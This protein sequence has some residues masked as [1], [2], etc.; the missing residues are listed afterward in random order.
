MS[1]EPVKNTVPAGRVEIYDT[2]L[3]D[4]AQGEGV[5]F[6]LQDKLA[7][8][9]KLDE[10]R[11]DYIEGGY[12]L[13]NAKD[14][15]FFK[16]IRKIELKHSK[17]AA[18]GMTRRRG[19]KAEED[20]CLL[21]LQKSLAPVVT[22]VGKGWD[23]QVK[24]V[25]GVSLE[26]NMKMVADSCSFL[27]KKKRD[28]FF[29]AEHFFD[30]YK[31][32]PVYSLKVLQAAADAG[33][34]RF[35]LCDTNGGSMVH[36]IQEI[37]AEVV[38]ALGI[39]VGIHAHNDCG[40]AVANSLGAVRAGAVQVQGT[41]NGLGERCGNADLCSVIP[42]L[43]FKFGKTVLNKS[44]MAKLTEASRFVY[45]TAN[46]NLPINQPFVGASSFTHKGGMHVHAIQK[47]TK[48]YEH[49]EPEMVGNT[50]KIIVSELSGASN[51]LA[52][53]EKLANLKDKNIVKKVLKEVQ[54]LENEGY[55]FEKAD[56]SLDLIIHKH[57]GK[58]EKFFELDH[59]R[60]IILKEGKADH[61]VSEATVKLTVNGKIEHRVA[62]GDGPVHSLDAALRQ[63][64]VSH[65]P[66][67]K[68]MQLVDYKVRVV[69]SKEASAAKVCVIIESRDNDSHW[70]TVGVSENII[71]ASWLALVDSFIYKL[72]K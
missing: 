49:I 33:A 19:V 14:E 72:L 35:I 1:K 54:D 70:G 26:E 31:A 71:D 61:A 5:S 6:S 29:D 36:E 30:G 58:N 66:K 67:L 18:F 8:S 37:T 65:Y 56:A 64:L 24:E 68:E 16:E 38:K 41:F 20:T 27:K 22:I 53:S 9:R 17:I 7:I 23:M 2:T 43:A 47:A 39:E 45:D 63:T 32:N 59:Y 48:T 62:E 3:R 34:I 57:L 51:L 25:L 13:S 40:L 28:V 60:S 52:R 21:A 10:L 46:I 44:A 50:R 69:N 11:V 12:P 15:A 4:G 42:N 55:Q